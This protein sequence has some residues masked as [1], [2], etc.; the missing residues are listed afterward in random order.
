MNPQPPVEL[1]DIQNFEGKYPKQLW[2][3]FFSIPL[4]R[5]VPEPSH[6]ADDGPPPAGG[7]LRVA[8]TRL[9]Q[10]IRRVR[11][12]RLRQTGERSFAA[13]DATD[14][15]GSTAPNRKRLR[16]LTGVNSLP[17]AFLR[18]WA[19]KHWSSA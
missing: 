3:L 18:P 12:V 7:P 14:P 11:A 2:W 13:V 5:R 15:V 9:L 6:R 16:L 8:L 17:V 10:S 4:F 1:S 19:C